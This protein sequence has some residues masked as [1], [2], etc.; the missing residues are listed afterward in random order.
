MKNRV[1]L[2]WCHSDD[3]MENAFVLA[4]DNR[5]ARGYF[6]GYNGYRSS[7]VY[8]MLIHRIPAAM[9][10]V[11]TFATDELLLSC[12]AVFEQVGETGRAVILNGLVFREG[13][14]EQHYT[15]MRQAPAY[16]SKMGDFR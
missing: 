1:S 4:R 6:A 16:S 3:Q 2:F 15:H 13:S 9:S 10:S 7:E 12:G 14:F 5:D 11:P 8:A